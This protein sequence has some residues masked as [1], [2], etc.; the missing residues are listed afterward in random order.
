MSPHLLPFVELLNIV[1]LVTYNYLMNE[2][3]R[4][5]VSEGGLIILC[6]IAIGSIKKIL[7]RL[8]DHYD[9]VATSAEYISFLCNG[10]DIT[11]STFL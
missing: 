5:P 9:P 7:L 11:T 3:N 10:T 8:S 6:N 1:R 4:L 2:L